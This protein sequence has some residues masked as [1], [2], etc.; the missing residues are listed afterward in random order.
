MNDTNLT[1]AEQRAIDAEKLRRWNWMMNYCKNS[2]VARGSEE[3]NNLWD[4]AA[5]EYVVFKENSGE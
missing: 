3:W 5:A 4:V 2:E 1:H